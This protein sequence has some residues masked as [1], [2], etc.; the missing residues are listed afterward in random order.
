MVKIMEKGIISALPYNLEAEQCVLGSILIDKE[1]Q[2]DIRAKLVREDFYI[3]SHK[4]VF[5][6][7]CSVLDNNKP[8]DIVILSDEMSK[9]PIKKD[10]RKKVDLATLVKEMEKNT[11]LSK[12]GGI[13]YLSELSRATPSASNYEYYLNIVKRD[14]LLRKLIRSADDIINDCKVSVDSKKSLSK[15]EA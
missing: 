12:A 3:E 8:V 13:E 5:D 10:K 4:L 9:T 6:S 7:I 15:A 14:S 11:T 1:L 2:F